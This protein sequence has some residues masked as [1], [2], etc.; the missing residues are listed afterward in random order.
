MLA[1]SHSLK[2]PRSPAQLRGYIL[3][4]VVAVTIFGLD[5]LSK[6][7]VVQHLGLGQSIGANSPISIQ[8]VENSG[9][10]FGF[11][12]QFQWLYLIVAAFVSAYILLAGYRFGTGWFRQVLLGFILGGALSNGIDR[13]LQGHVVDFIQLHWWPV[14][15]IAD[16][17]IVLGILGVILTFR[18]RAAPAPS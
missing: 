2:K 4:L 18:P 14:F 7:L 13:L 1:G 5:H 10:A 16:S 8:H 3:L 17:A 15:N 6:W 9:A 11:G 12:P